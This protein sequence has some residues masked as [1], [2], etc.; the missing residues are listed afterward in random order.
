M[1]GGDVTVRLNAA[2]CECATRGKMP[3]RAFIGTDAMHA[4]AQSF[5][6]LSY[7]MFGGFTSLTFNGPTGPI[8]LTVRP[9]LHAAVIVEAE[10]GEPFIHEPRDD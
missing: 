1:T 3:A 5:A 2:A 9:M 10:D 7:G 4:L 6:R 8:P